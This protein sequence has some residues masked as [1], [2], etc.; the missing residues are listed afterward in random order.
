VGAG[1]CSCPFSWAPQAHCPVYYRLSPTVNLLAAQ[2]AGAIYPVSQKRQAKGSPA[3][4]HYY[5]KKIGS[6]IT[7]L[8]FIAFFVV[9]LIYGGHH[10]LAHRTAGK[11]YDGGSSRARAGQFG[12]G[13]GAESDLPDGTAYHDKSDG[14]VFPLIAY[15]CFSRST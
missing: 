10:Q 8:Y 13:A 15:S 5:G 12:R 11:T 9:V 2:R 1:T 4:T 14:L 3:V 7:T 6:L